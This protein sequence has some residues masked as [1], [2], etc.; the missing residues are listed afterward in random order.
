MSHFQERYEAAIHRSAK[1]T[2]AEIRQQ[3]WSWGG[4]LSQNSSRKESE[5][6]VLFSNWNTWAVVNKTNNKWGNKLI[7][8][9]FCSIRQQS[10]LCGI[11]VCEMTLGFPH[12]PQSS[13]FMNW[14]WCWPL[15]LC[16]SWLP[17]S[18]TSLMGP[19]TLT[20]SL[21]IA[22]SGIEVWCFIPALAG[23]SILPYI[24]APTAAVLRSILF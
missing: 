19:Y 21:L 24:P 23:R 4:T 5:R 9:L 6:S 14:N 22:Q 11:Y 20:R 15:H 16:L 17:V 1:K 2:W 3:R 10:F 12:K 13:V 7:N 18:P 8:Q